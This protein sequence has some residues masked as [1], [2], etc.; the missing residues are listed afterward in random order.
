[1]SRRAVPWTMML[2]ALSACVGGAEPMSPETAVLASPSHAPGWR[3]DIQSAR[4]ALLAADA[5]QTRAA[6]SG[7]F[8]D[9]FAASLAP[10]AVYLPPGGHAIQG[11]DHI[12]AYLAATYPDGTTLVR[13]PLR[14]DVSA[15]GSVGL[16]F[17]H[18]ETVL[19]GSSGV[20]YGKYVAAWRW[21]SG[22]WKL[23]GYLPN[24]SPRPSAPPPAWYHDL[25]DN[26]VR[27]AE[28][29]DAAEQLASVLAA[30]AAFSAASVA[31]G[32]G[33]AFYEFAHREGIV[34]LNGSGVA[35]G[36]DVIRAV[37]TLPPGYQLSWTPQGGTAA[38]TADLAFTWGTYEFLLPS[39][40]ISHGKYMSLWEKTPP[41]EWK[42]VADAGNTNPAPGS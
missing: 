36:P 26:G 16:T 7:S 22:G 21:D 32:T 37:Y 25:V 19:P 38:S 34:L 9:G 24:G 31:W 12:H 10:D 18:S 13:Q 28:P 4:E 40:A 2:L 20:G 41:G 8:A 42:F 17:G 1:M 5:T 6:S 33:P 30:D 15:D 29:G 23:E 27:A 35:Y 11:A 3:V 39:G 14:A